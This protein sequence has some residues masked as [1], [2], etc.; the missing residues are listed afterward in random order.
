VGLT[1]RPGSLMGIIAKDPG[2]LETYRD[3]FAEDETVKCLTM[4]EA[5]GVEFDLV[6]LLESEDEAVDWDDADLAAEQIRTQRDLR[7]VAL[8]RAMSELH[9]V[10][11]G[12][13]MV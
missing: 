12:F 6:V 1:R 2:V 4:R 5:Q 9:V 10:R 13:M 8:T 3:Y 7:Y 11:H